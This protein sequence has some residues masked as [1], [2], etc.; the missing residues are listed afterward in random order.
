[1]SWTSSPLDAKSVATRMRTRPANHA[2]CEWDARSNILVTSAP[3]PVSVGHVLSLKSWKACSRSHCSWP[4]WRHCSR[5]PCRLMSLAR[6]SALTLPRVRTTGL[7]QSQSASTMTPFSPVGELS[8]SHDFFADKDEN[9]VLRRHASDEVQQVRLLLLFA[10]NQHRLLHWVDSLRHRTKW[11]YFK[12]F[13]LF[14]SRVE[15]INC[16]FDGAIK[17]QKVDC[18]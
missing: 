3:V 5:S 1:M 6:S 2:S 7:R 9:F 15:V 8:N 4:P 18:Q 11:H 10:D 13:I 12:I 16:L 17:I 14:K